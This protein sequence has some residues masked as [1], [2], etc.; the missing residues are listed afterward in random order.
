MMNTKEGNKMILVIST[1]HYENYGAHDWDGVGAC[2][3][4]WKAKGGDEI[5]ITDVDTGLYTADQI[6]EMVRGD[7]EMRNEGFECTIIGYGF[8]EDGYMSWFE[9]SQLDYEGKVTH[10]ETRITMGEV[11]GRWLNLE[12]PK[13]YAEASADADAIYY[14]A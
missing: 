11:V 4:Y 6:V 9:K 10:P 1:Q 2:P 13:A 8:Q 12:D 7:I 5:M 3:Q 14:G